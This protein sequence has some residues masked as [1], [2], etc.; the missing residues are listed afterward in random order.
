MKLIS[1]AY[2]KTVFAP[3]NISAEVVNGVPFPSGYVFTDNPG[4][5]EVVITGQKTIDSICMY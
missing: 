5:D 1:W 3:G 4:E 2:S